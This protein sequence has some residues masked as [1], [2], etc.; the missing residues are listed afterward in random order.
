MTKWQVVLLVC[1]W[2]CFGD[3]ACLF[4]GA[5]VG[6]PMSIDG[7]LRVQGN[8]YVGG[9]ATVHGPIQVRSLSV[10]GSVV[11]TL[12]K[13]EPAGFAGQDYATSLTVGG[14]LT[15]NGPLI[16]DGSL[17]VGGP[18]T[19]ES[20]PQVLR[21]YPRPAQPLSP[22]REPESGEAPVQGATG[23]QSWTE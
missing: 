18:L 7:P 6:G 12:P 14:P 9:P 1:L 2:C 22:G 23:E 15:V 4:A 8:L 11:T 5:S 19:C 3:C 17:R 20:M 13:G 16:V 10:G 21:D